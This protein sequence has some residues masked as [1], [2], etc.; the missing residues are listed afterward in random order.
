MALILCSATLLKSTSFLI[1]VIS[2]ADEE[3]EWKDVDEQKGKQQDD[4]L[5]YDGHDR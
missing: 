4:R 2:R 3:N 1:H 5:A